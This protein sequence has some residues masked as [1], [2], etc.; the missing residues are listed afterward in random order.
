M[1]MKFQDLSFYLTLVFFLF[2]FHPSFGTNNLDFNNNCPTAG[3]PCDDNNPLTSNDMED[4][5]CN[6]VGLAICGDGSVSSKGPTGATRNPWQ[7]TT[8]QYEMYENMPVSTING[9]PG[10]H[11]TYGALPLPDV[12]YYTNIKDNGASPSS[13]L[14]QFRFQGA[15]SHFLKDDPIV[16]PNQP[17]ASHLHMFFGNTRA[18]AYSTVGTGNQTDLL[19]RGAS[20]V[21]GGKGANPS[22]YWVPALVDGPL[23]G[24]GNERKIILPDVITIYYKSRKLYAM[25]MVPAGLQIIGGN[26]PHTPNPNG[27]VHNMIIKNSSGGDRRE[28]ARWGFYDNGLITGGGPTIPQSNPG[29]HKYIRAAIGFPQCF[30]ANPDGSFVFSSPNNLDHQHLL[31]DSGGWNRDD[32]DCPGSHPNR[33][34]KVEILL[35]YRWPANGDVSG[36]RLSSDMGANTDAQVPYPGGSL[37][38]DILFAWNE[39]VQ[40]AWKDECMDPNDPRNCS[41]GQTGTNYNLDRIANTGTITNQI[42]YGPTSALKDP[43]DCG[44]CPPAGTPCDDN[45]SNTVNDVYDAQCNCAGTCIAAGTPC[46]DSDPAT[47]NDVHDGSCNCAGT[48][49]AAGT[50]CDD[51]DPDTVNDVW[52]GQCN[53][54]G[55]C[56]VVGTPCDDNDPTTTNDTYDGQCNCTGTFVP[57][58]GI[59]QF[60]TPP[61]LDGFDNEWTADSTLLVNKVL[62]GTIANPSDLRAEY[63]LGWD[64]NY[65][66][67]FGKVNDNVLINDS[68]NPWNDD[69]FELYID[70]GNDKA[71]TYDA[72]DFQLMFRYNDATVYNFPTGPASPQGVDFVMVPT[73]SGYHVEIRVS[74]SFIGIPP[75]TEGSKIGLDV[76][77]NDDDDGGARDKFIS[78]ND[79]VNLAWTNPSV[80]GEIL[81]EDCQSAFITPDICLWME[82]AYDFG[83]NQMTTLLTQRNLVP[84]SQPYNTAPWNYGGTETYNTLPPPSVDWVKVSFR[85]DPSKSSEVLATAAMLLEDGCLDFPDE[86]FF[87]ESLGSQFYVVVEHRNHIG[88]MS[89]TAVGVSQGMLTYD[90]RSGDSYAMGGQGQKQLA[91]GVWA[92]FAGDGDQLLDINGYD[93]NGVDNSSWLPQNGQFNVYGFGDYNLDGDVSGMDKILWSVNNGVYSTVDR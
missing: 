81:F 3:T 89:P 36:W 71:T 49:I 17:G 21:Q 24:C 23:G 79:D 30:K 43:Y 77:V 41:I 76:H 27:M 48:C 35:D 38:G 37:H 75:V 66:Y 28:G 70:G 1:H 83:V 82:G 46:D 57:G 5:N 93:I 69:C 52:D 14:G 56:A 42:Y 74:W 19:V 18:D 65:L 84:L 51:N 4:G 85:T 6:C 86:D 91:S 47:V 33:I 59:C 39:K 60:D 87:P 44:S 8:Q 31:E 50:T 58:Q 7:M 16:F 9:L 90:F 92:M 88:V 68:P 29:G 13:V 62:G 32:L 63:K 80:F 26:I 10:H 67:V 78:W 12:S 55:T 61:V 15:P 64:D 25:K 34:A 45:D 53:C 54:A 11:P 73:S 72:N 40:K 20:T 22:S 2:C